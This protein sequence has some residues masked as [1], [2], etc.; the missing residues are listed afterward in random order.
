MGLHP[1]I[2][3]TGAGGQVGRALKKEIPHG[4]FFDHG[5]LDVR[6]A[7]AVRDAVR[8]A[9]V[10]VHLAAMTD[11]DAC[12]SEADLAHT[13]NVTGTRNVAGAAHAG[14]AR[15]I[16]LSSDYVFD[17]DKTGEYAEGDAPNPLNVYGRTKLEGEQI[18][19]SRPGSLVV[20]SS[21][22]FGEGRNF[23]RS[24]LAKARQQDALRVVDDQRG[25][26]TCAS[27]LALAIAHAIENEIEGIVHVAGVGDPCT[28]AEL[29]RATVAEAYLDARVEA[30]DSATYRDQADRVVAQRPS[31]S[32][33]S[34]VKAGQLHFPLKDW[35]ESL[36]R[37]VGEVL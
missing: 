24:I 22:V 29:A 25:R 37:Y 19:L 23:V 31:N 21:W 26:P 2:L 8:G 36:G 30:I 6:D 33:L 18:V 17:G 34:L 10:V 27:D 28:W 32:S 11:V 9:D 16:F 35:R 13:I 12:E 5:R 14:E 7:D 4:L 20:R 3:V 15:V 1:R